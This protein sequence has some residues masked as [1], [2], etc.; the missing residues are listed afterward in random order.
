MSRCL[1]AV[2]MTYLGLC[3]DLVTFHRTKYRSLR[4]FCQVLIVISSTIYM[5]KDIFFLQ[6]SRFAGIAA[7]CRIERFKVKQASPAFSLIRMARHARKQQ[8]RKHTRNKGDN[9]GTVHYRQRF[10]EQK[11]ANSVDHMSILLRTGPILRMIGSV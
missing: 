11:R 5:N 3:L 4:P 1:L 6:N 7:S 9:S 10:W 2:C 8:V